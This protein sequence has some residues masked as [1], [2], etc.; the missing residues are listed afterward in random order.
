MKRSKKNEKQKAIQEQINKKCLMAIHDYN[1]TADS[2][3]GMKETQLNSCTAWYFETKD[4]LVL[5][6]YRTIVALYDKNNNNFYDILRYVYGYTATSAQ[7]IAKFRNLLRYKGYINSY[8][9][10][11][12]Y[13]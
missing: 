7:H 8:T 12:R 10:F 1:I 4:C 9:C 6:S 11:Y 3:D 13:Y 5:R 2:Y